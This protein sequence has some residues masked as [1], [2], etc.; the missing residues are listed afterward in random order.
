M[1][2]IILSNPNSWVFYPR[3]THQIVPKAQTILERG[4]KKIWS[5]KNEKNLCLFI[6][7]IDPHRPPSPTDHRVSQEGHDETQQNVK[8]SS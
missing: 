3:N 4:R 1:S 2:N 6:N 8:F 5:E 7:Q